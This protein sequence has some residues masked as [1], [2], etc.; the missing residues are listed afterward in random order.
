MR[1][2]RLEVCT[3]YVPIFNVTFRN[4]EH[5]KKRLVNKLKRKKPLRSTWDHVKSSKQSNSR[6]Q[7]HVRERH[8]FIQGHDFKIYF[9]HATLSVGI[10]FVSR[11]SARMPKLTGLRARSI[12]LKLWRRTRK[13]Q[14]FIVRLLSL[15]I[16]QSPRKRA[17]LR[18]I[19]VSR[20]AYVLRPCHGYADHW[21]EIFRFA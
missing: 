3:L 2:D 14:Y 15:N 20:Q 1:N 18:G 17:R 7:E 12:L 8:F 16:P 19:K 21:F 6:A 4:G 13:G 11:F 10:A 9:F 5:A